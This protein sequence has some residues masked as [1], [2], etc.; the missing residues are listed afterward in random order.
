MLDQKEIESNRTFK[1]LADQAKKGDQDGRW[2]AF[3]AVNKLP[4]DSTIIVEIPAGTP[5]AEGPNKTKTAQS[6]SFRTYPPLALDEVRCGYS[7][8]GQCPPGS[9]LTFHFNNPIDEAKFDDKLV[10]VSPAIDGMKVIAQGNAV[11]VI[12][13]TKSRQTYEVS[14]AAG[15]VDEF[16][17]TL[18]NRVSEKFTIGDANPN[19]FGP[20]GVV[21]LDPAASKR[22]FDFFSTNHGAFKVR[23]YKVTPSDLKA[24][25]FYQQNQWNQDNPPRLP[26]IKVFDQ[27]IKPEDKPNELIETN[28]DLMPALSKDGF[29][30]AIV[31][32]E[33]TPWTQRYRP[34][35]IIA[36]VQATKLA[37][38][39]HVD[40]ENLQA[41]V[42]ELDGAAP[43]SGVTVEMFPARTTA[44]TDAQGLATIPLGP[45]IT[46]T[47]YL[48]AK[49]GN[50]T[51]FVSEDSYFN[52]YGS[53]YRQAR[54]RDI[55]WY[56]FDDRK[57]YKPGRLLPRF[58][59]RL[60]RCYCE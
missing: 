42:T 39:A 1:F 56:V 28:L 15:L 27:V 43:A 57:L 55:A 3:R 32:I 7:Y 9:A 45:S 19:F 8:A 40:S 10:T 17:Q 30:H 6:F 23:I 20:R 46:G 37:V 14:I 13:A 33:P 22:T 52:D 24:Y 38:D 4:V 48:L 16:K 47:Y 36:W 50:D 34:P 51:A 49:R 59:F 18:A 2:L 26:G 41:F 44:T 29:G 35:N 53:W 12:G 58:S 25:G 31:H 5:S 21:V 54:E 60:N 11:A